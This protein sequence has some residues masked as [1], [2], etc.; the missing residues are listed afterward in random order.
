LRTL[1][2]VL[3]DCIAIAAEQIEAA[4]TLDIAGLDEATALRKDLLFE[5]DVATKNTT[6]LSSEAEELA[7]EL[8]ELDARLERLLTAGLTTIEN[9]RSQREV[10]VYTH[11]GRIKGNTQ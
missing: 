5:L 1:D 2:E 4:R 7:H 11:E 3:R 10:P 6:S 9:I 8:R